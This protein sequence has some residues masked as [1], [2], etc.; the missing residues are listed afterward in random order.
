MNGDVF[1]VA[2]ETGRP[3]DARFSISDQDIV[4]HSRGGTKGRDA[5]NVDYS[6]GLLTILERLALNGVRIVGAWVDS[7]TVRSMP[8]DARSILQGTDCG[9]PPERMLAMM[10]V[11]MKDVR[12]NP[13]STARGGNSTRRIRIVTAFEGSGKAL[14]DLLGG[15]PAERDLRSRERLPTSTLER[16]TPEFVWTAVQRFVDGKVEHVFGPSTDFDLIADGD[17][18]LPPK[19]VFGVALSI[20]LG[21]TVQPKHF[22]GGESSAC[23]SLLRRAGFPVVRKGTL[24][25]ADEA[26]EDADDTQSWNEGRI[27]LESHLKRERAKGLSL[28]KKDQYRRLYGRLAC[29]RCGLDPVSSYGTVHAEACIEVHHSKIQVSR[30]AEGHATVL[31]DLLCLCANCHRL[32]HRL[33]RTS[34]L[35]YV[36]SP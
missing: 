9:Q 7:S 18:R 28:A 32:V 11:R 26:V 12:S 10:S 14:A 6:R 27:R 3:I 24:L 5:L 36:D 20:A 16:A 33:L 29:E 8:P 22:A 34:S 31:E 30:M 4:V 21:E 1:V 17:L 19:A 23:F 2:D 15:V 25:P 35:P 13:A